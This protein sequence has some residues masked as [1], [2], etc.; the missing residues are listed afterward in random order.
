VNDER[1]PIIVQ[2][3]AGAVDDPSDL[4]NLYV[5]GSESQLVPLTQLI[6]FKE[7]AVAGELDRHGLRRAV[8]IFGDAVPGYSLR[9]AVTAIEQ[10]AERALPP[11]MSFLF[12]DEA[13]ALNETSHAVATTYIVALIIVFL[14]LVAQF[15]SLTSALVV[16][17]TVPFGVCAAVFAL[18]LTG[19][20]INIY[21]Q[22]GIL[23]LIGIMAKNAI[24]MVEFADQLRENGLGVAAA[25]YEASMVRLRPIMMTM[26]STVFAGLPLILGSGPG[27]EARGAIGWVVF[28]GLGLAAVFTLLLTPA[29]Y[30]LIAGL[31]RPRNAE[32][33][34]VDRE[35]D[36]ARAMLGTTI[37][38]K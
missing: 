17:L 23:M 4:S 14:V 37:T 1:L 11:G 13:A 5:R 8:A 15:E 34:R 21:S 33:E 27:Q 30:V 7:Y 16:L 20:S 31:V 12:L 32:T 29:L 19:T 10:V 2:A 9:Q 36:D 25:A 24:L 18:A 22:I 3:T 28:G 26:L 38:S 6:T 35:L